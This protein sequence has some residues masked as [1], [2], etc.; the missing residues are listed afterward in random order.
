MSEGMSEIMLDMNLM[1]LFI[2]CVCHHTSGQTHIFPY[3]D[4]NIKALPETPEKS[5]SPDP[6][7]EPTSYAQSE[8]TT[9]PEVDYSPPQA[10]Q[11][12]S[13]IQSRD[14]SVDSTDLNLRIEQPTTVQPAPGPIASAIQGTL[15]LSGDY[16]DYSNYYSAFYQAHHQ[17][18][19]NHYFSNHFTVSSLI[20]K[21]P[22]A[23]SPVPYPKRVPL[24]GSLE[25]R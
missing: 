3:Y 20:Q 24:E 8:V 12:V 10:T 18:D 4:Q 11:H 23:T 21:P 9:P 22:V 2:P 25:N 13:P 5:T 1:S 16:A 17:T 14:T 15:G 6:S 7:H 19:P